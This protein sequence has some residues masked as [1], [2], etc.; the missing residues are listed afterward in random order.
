MSLRAPFHLQPPP[1]STEA[2]DLSSFSRAYRAVAPA[3]QAWARLQVGPRLSGSIS[4]EDLIQ[5]TW[6]RA[7]LGLGRFDPERGSFR[8]YLFGIAEKVLLE[9][10]RRLA[11]RPL[12]SQPSSSHIPAVLREAA[13][14]ITSISERASRS[15]FVTRLLQVA[16]QLDEEERQLLVWRGLEEQP[17]DEIGR[18]LGQRDEAA[19]SRWRRLRARLQRDLREHGGGL[20]QD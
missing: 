9:E 4:P 3:L 16:A 18:R 13:A 12:H 19:R 20:P 14:E 2:L 10:L 1:S 15:E 7:F 11:R 6:C 8:A 5:E 17:F